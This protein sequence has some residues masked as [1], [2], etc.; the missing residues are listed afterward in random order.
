MEVTCVMNISDLAKYSS[1]VCAAF[2][3][4]AGCSSGGSES[5]LGPPQSTQRNAFSPAMVPSPLSR[6]PTLSRNVHADH[7]QSWIAPDAKRQNL[8]Y[9]SDAATFYVDFYSYPKGVLKGQITDLNGEPHGLCVDKAGDVFVPV[10]GGQDILEYA[11]GGTSPIKTLSDPG[12]YPWGCSVDPTTGNLA[13]TN[14]RKQYS[15]GGN[16]L[17]YK[18]A[19][20]TPRTYTDPELPGPWFAGYDDK[21]NLFVDGQNVGGQFG[22]AELPRGKNKFTN[23]TLN[24]SI[25]VP[26]GVQWDGTHVAVVDQQASPSVIYQFI[27]SGSN[28]TEVGSTTLNN[29][30]NLFQFWIQ[31]GRVISPQGTTV[32]I[33][34]YPAGGQRIQTIYNL[35]DAVG[36]TVSHRPL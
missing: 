21:G 23:I 8:L 32:E 7:R 10:G 19:S 15:Y 34:D 6:V 16:V 12:Y 17:V 29:S 4:L 28:G 30:V 36:A 22:F 25:S 35:G 14:K 1:A 27:I 18:N 2:V 11:H 13:V 20:G 26:G 24:Q 3:L 31:G 9:V 5:Q 33:Y